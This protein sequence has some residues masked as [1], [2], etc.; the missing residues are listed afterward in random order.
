MHALYVHVCVC[1]WKYVCLSSS[2]RRFNPAIFMV[3]SL[4]FHSH[5]SR[6]PPSDYGMGR[7]FALFRSIR[8]YTHLPAP[9][10]PSP[11][12]AAPPAHSKQIKRNSTHESKVI[13]VVSRLTS[14]KVNSKT[15]VR[16]CKR[17]VG[18]QSPSS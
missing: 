11:H 7:L 17:M 10:L 4:Q 2:L 18:H 8:V 15:L 12:P 6:T 9:C 14:L 3:R 16:E 13:C 5:F 1:L